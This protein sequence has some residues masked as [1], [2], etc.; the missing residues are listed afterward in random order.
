MFSVQTLGGRWVGRAEVAM[1]Q[2]SGL[3][4]VPI[5]GTTPYLSNFCARLGVGEVLC[6]ST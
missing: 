1:M 3:Y 5:P 4:S 6:T 2:L